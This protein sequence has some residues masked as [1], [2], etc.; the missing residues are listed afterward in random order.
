MYE[1]Q[2]FKFSGTKTETQHC[3]TVSSAWGKMIVGCGLI[4]FSFN[5]CAPKTMYKTENIVETIFKKSSEKSLFLEIGQSRIDR[6][7]TITP[8][9]ILPSSTDGSIEL[10][11]EI[12][13]KTAEE[14]TL[15]QTNFKSG[16]TKHI[17]FSDGTTLAI[18][19]GSIRADSPNSKGGAGISV[20]KTDE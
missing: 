17:S 2:K 7:Y 16:Q 19:V 14:E 11:L 15:M 9:G 5:A 10:V 4:A 20:K 8:I 3:D 18:R 13:I 12:Y 1:P 6:G